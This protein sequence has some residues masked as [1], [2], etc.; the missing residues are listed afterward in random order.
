M[1]PKAAD[2]AA[3]AMNRSR[4][5][6]G[7]LNG[8]TGNRLHAALGAAGCNLRG[9]LWMIAKKGL[10]AILCLLPTHLRSAVRAAFNADQT[11]LDPMAAM[12]LASVG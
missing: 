9:L 6:M 1:A 5:Q 4:V 7:H 12:R 11:E 8:Q 10:R 3:V 2:A